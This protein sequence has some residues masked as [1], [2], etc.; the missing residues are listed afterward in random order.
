M[1]KFYAAKR[2]EHRLAMARRNEATT[3]TRKKTSGLNVQ[4]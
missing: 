2:I 1:P 4:E 3:S